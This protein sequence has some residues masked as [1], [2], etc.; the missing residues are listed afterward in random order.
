MTV[1]FPDLNTWHRVGDWSAFASAYPIA[2]CRATM[3]VSEV[4]AYFFDFLAGCWNHGVRPIAYHRLRPDMDPAKQADHLLRIAGPHC[5]YALD[6]ETTKGAARE[7]TVPEGAAFL[8]RIDERTGRGR[9]H[10]LSYLPRWWYD[11][12]GAGRTDLKGSLLWA[13]RYTRPINWQPYAGFE[14]MTIMQFSDAHPWAGGG[15]GDMNEYRGTLDELKI[16][17]GFK[18]DAADKAWLEGALA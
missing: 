17:L 12:H 2:A 6:L 14:Q 18:L 8:D 11:A 4:D 9:S 1:L 13:S 5:A 16:S 10:L 15:G 3:G 7:P